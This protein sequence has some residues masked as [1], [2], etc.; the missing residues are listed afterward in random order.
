MASDVAS[1][2][3]SSWNMNSV[4]YSLRN[5]LERASSRNREYTRL[6]SLTSTSV[7]WK[8]IKERWS[9]VRGRGFVRGSKQADY[10]K[11]KRRKR[12]R[13]C[14]KTCQKESSSSTVRTTRPWLQ[15]NL[16]WALV[17][18]KLQKNAWPRWT[19]NLSPRYGHLI[20]ASGY[21]D[22][23]GDNWREQGCP[24]SKNNAINHWAACSCQP[25]S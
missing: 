6:M 14:W 13:T 4:W 23:T 5:W 2:D 15:V 17:S 8:K 1:V 7:P 19:L 10:A 21:L 24:I 20:L 25:I 16:T 12:L 11:Y 3:S 9:E 22:L 18:G